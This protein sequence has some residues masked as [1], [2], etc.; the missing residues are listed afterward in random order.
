M[1]PGRAEEVPRLGIG[2]VDVRPGV[3]DHRLLADH[4]LEGQLVVVRVA[5]VPVAARVAAA[6]DHVQ[7]LAPQHV[8]AAFRVGGALPGGGV[9]A[10]GLVEEVPVVAHGR[11][12]RSRRAAGSGRR[13]RR[14]SAARARRA[15][16][17]RGRRRASSR[18]GR[19]AS[20]ASGAGRARRRPVSR[21]GRARSRAG[22]RGSRPRARS[23]RR[24]PDAPS[25]RRARRPP[26]RPSPCP[27][28]RRRTEAATAQQPDDVGQV[29]V[30][31]NAAVLGVRADEPAVQEEAFERGL[32]PGLA[33]R[34]PPRREPALRPSSPPGSRRPS[35]DAQLGPSSTGFA[36]DPGRELGAELVEVAPLAGLAPGGRE[37]RQVLAPGELPRHL[38]VRA[39]AVGD[40]EER[41]VAKRPAAAGLEVRVPVDL[42][43]EVGGTGAQK[44]EAVRADLVGPLGA[45]R[46]SAPAPARSARRSAEPR[47]RVRGAPGPDRC[48]QGRPGAGPGRRSPAE[49]VVALPSRRR[50]ARRA[51]PRTAACAPR[52]TPAR[53]SCATTSRALGR[54]VRRRG[55]ARRPR[56]RAR[57]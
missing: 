9:R 57:R 24:A 6:D 13:R 40:R 22:G 11:G 31:A 53:R 14:R 44:V 7:A 36:S 46:R 17:S 48:P 16:C 41:G 51:P 37:Q 3:G 33:R 32:E 52:L 42:G 8:E 34:C 47:A 21:R 28:S 54:T 26:S 35:C 30:A 23:R 19:G 20:R 43:P 56:G 10:V 29:V 55:C 38:D 15:A 25:R 1:V 12:A 2:G 50:R 39:V 5:A 18:V 45:G 4:E 49:L 27:P